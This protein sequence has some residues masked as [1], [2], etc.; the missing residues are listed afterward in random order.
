[1]PLY[2]RLALIASATRYSSRSQWQERKQS[3]IDS[4][5]KLSWELIM[6]SVNGL[7]DNA[8]VTVVQTLALLALIDATGKL[9]QSMS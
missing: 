8:D 4:Y 6:T 9:E 1:M 7:D 5:A 2:L 3:T